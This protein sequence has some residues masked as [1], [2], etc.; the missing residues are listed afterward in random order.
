MVLYTLMPNLC[1]MPRAASTVMQYASCTLPFAL[2]HV[3]VLYITMLLA[4]IWQSESQGASAV[5]APIFSC[6]F[7][8]GPEGP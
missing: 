4:H 6:T 2:Q 7:Q 5:P 1:G 3:N 8:A